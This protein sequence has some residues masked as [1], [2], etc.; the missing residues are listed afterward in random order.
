MTQE[1]KAKAYDE[2]LEKAQKATRAGSD[3]AMDI[4]QY[5]FPELRESEE[6]KIRNE[7]LIYI[8]ARQD[9]DLETHNR[10]CAYLEKQK[11]QKPVEIDEY[12][13]IEKH[14]TEDSLSSE[15]NKRLKEC[16]WY[17]TDE[18]P[19]KWG[20]GDENK[21]YQAVETLLADKAIALQENPHCKA[22]HRAYDDLIVWLKSL[23]KRFNFQPK[24][25]W[26]EEDEKIYN[27]IIKI[28]FES[29]STLSLEYV[30][31]I[32]NWLKSLPERL[33]LPSKQEWS[34]GTKKALDKISD[35][36]KYKGREEDADF[37]RHLC[38]QPKKEWSEEDEEHL[39][40]IIESYKEL[41]KDYSANNGVDYI[42]YNTPVVARTVL[43]DI[44][45]LKSLPERL[46][47]P[48]KQEWSEEDYNAILIAIDWLQYY[49]DTFVATGEAKD[50]ISTCV[51]RLKSLRP[52]PKQEWSEEDEGKIEDILLIIK[53]VTNIPYSGG[54][55]TINNEYKDELSKF[56]K[57]FVPNAEN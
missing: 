27:I 8:G 2:A 51:D 22:L 21:L 34:E 35:Y 23:P 50:E 47:L 45:F 26:S 56:L 33:N 5:I 55:L 13:I 46:N 16:G 9:I 28:I 38:P 30:D 32:N 37:I 48:S 41:L 20:D 24:Q 12:K 57:S 53:H 31:E 14:I 49:R 15:V 29:K 7:I 40:S 1:E 4:V 18:K 11:E 42:P 25:G 43:N 10:W 3:V 6:E 36:L 39:N 52:Q 44:K 19:A 54:I 17:V